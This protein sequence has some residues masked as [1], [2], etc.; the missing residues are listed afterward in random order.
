MG[1]ATPFAQT[2]AQEAVPLQS[3]RC[4]KENTRC[5][6]EGFSPKVGGNEPLCKV[7]AAAVF[8]QLEVNP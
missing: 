6:S 7:L 5:Q 1:V 8:L 2:S 3:W 4:R